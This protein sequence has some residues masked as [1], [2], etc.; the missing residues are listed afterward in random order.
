MF[1]EILAHYVN[2]SASCLLTR[3]WRS[4]ISVQKYCFLNDHIV[5][6]TWIH[7]N[8]FKEFPT[9]SNFSCFQTFAI[10]TNA[11]IETLSLYHLARVQIEMIL[12]SGV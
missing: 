8:L 1:S 2:S 10:T 3:S 6:Y 11:S 7:H 5:F 12:L 9:D 4:S